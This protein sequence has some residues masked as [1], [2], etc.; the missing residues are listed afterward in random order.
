MLRHLSILPVGGSGALEHDTVRLEFSGPA[1]QE[2]NNPYCFNKMLHVTIYAN[3][4]AYILNW[5]VQW[6]RRLWANHLLMLSWGGCAQTGRTL[7]FSFV[8]KCQQQQQKKQSASHFTWPFLN[9][10]AVAVRLLVGTANPIAIGIAGGSLYG[11]PLWVGFIR[12]VSSGVSG[13]WHGA[14]A[15]A[16][17]HPL[18]LVQ[19]WGAWLR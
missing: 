16:D 3:A 10:P 5:Y 9:A 19:A 14:A 12:N 8:S 2:K 17:V 4:Y 7:C 13:R 15:I 1:L 11:V 6:V 18:H